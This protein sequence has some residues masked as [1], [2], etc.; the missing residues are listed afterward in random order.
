MTTQTIKESIAYATELTNQLRH[1]IHQ[2]NDAVCEE[3]SNKEK[4]GISST[5]EMLLSN[6]ILP[7]LTLTVDLYGHLAGIDGIYNGEANNVTD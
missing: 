3:M 2:L 1:A 4:Q 7:N 5:E 6:M